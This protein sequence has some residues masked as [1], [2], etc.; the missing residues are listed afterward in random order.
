MDDERAAVVPI[1]PGVELVAPSPIRVR[2]LRASLRITDPPHPSNFGMEPNMR[3][4]RLPDM[5]D[6][7]HASAGQAA[8]EL[9]ALLAPMFPGREVTIACGYVWDEA[10]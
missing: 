7:W 6:R 9:E 1:R 2:V 3:E 5:I 4:V 10:Q 8:L